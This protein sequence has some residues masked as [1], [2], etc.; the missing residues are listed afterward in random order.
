MRRLLGLLI[1]ITSLY[2][3]FDKVATTA[4]PFL[5]LGV[6]ARAVSMGGG[7]VAL[8]N[9][10]SSIYWN[11]AGML[12]TQ[13]MTIAASHNDWLLDI[14]HDY[15]GLI[16]STSPS[17][18]IGLSITSLTMGEQPVRTLQDPEGTGIKYGVQD[19]N[20]N[21]AYARQITDRLSVG[22][23]L[24]MIQ[25]QAYNESARTFAMDIGSILETD[26]YGLKIGMAL[27]NFGG[28]IQ[29]S[30]RD[31]IID[32]DIDTDIG[33]NYNSDA[34]LRTEPW[35]LP[36]M[37]RIGVSLDIIGS[38]PAIMHSSTNRLTVALD[39]D[40]PNDGPE[41]LNGG[42]E[43]SFRE[44]MFF[45]AGYRHKYDLESITLGVGTK[46]HIRGLGEVHVDYAV[47]PKQR[48]GNTSIL[49]VEF[50]K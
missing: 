20:F 5:K 33:G 37:I 41:H 12:H 6:G 9:D 48:F 15:I 34:D 2:A 36:L 30:G 44:M 8:A 17:G 21:L 29:Y 50:Q 45:R 19:L 40:H 42:L 7:F 39:A 1:I 38:E 4:A 35:P 23:T 25:L 14:S 32:T 3:E 28:D 16:V 43:F 47:V 31:L 18:K 26:F 46:F 10:G 27:S 24:K 13:G 22:M 11:P 49:S